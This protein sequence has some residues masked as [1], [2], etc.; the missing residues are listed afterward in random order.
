MTSVQRSN[1]TRITCS[2]LVLLCVNLF[3]LYLTANLALLSVVFF[4]SLFAVV[5]W[6]NAR[7]PDRYFEDLPLLSFLTVVYW[8]FLFVDSHGTFQFFNFNTYEMNNYNT[9]VFLL[10]N[11]KLGIITGGALHDFAYYKGVNFV[12]FGPF[13]AIF[14]LMLKYAFDLT[15]TFSEITLIFVLINLIEFNLLLTDLARFS[16]LDGNTLGTRFLFL[17]LYAIGPLLY[18]TWRY[19]IYET[20]II[21]G[22]TFSL[23]ACILFLRYFNERG[24]SLRVK[25][26][27]LFGSGL[28]LALTFFSRVT[29][30]IIFVPLLIFL[31]WDVFLSHYN[32]ARLHRGWLLLIVFVIP[33]LCAGI[34][35][36]Y[37][38]MIRFGSP[39]EFGHNYVLS[40]VAVEVMRLQAGQV[41]SLGYL[42]RN[43]YQAFFFIPPMSRRYPFIYYNRYPGWLVGYSY[44]KLT[45]IEWGAS[46]FFSSPL[47]SF[48]FLSL[49]TLRRHGSWKYISVLA[50][51]SVCSGLYALSYMSYSRRYLQEFYPYVVALAFLGVIWV[52][53]RLRSFG[54]G[55]RLALTLVLIA[56]FIWTLFVS[57][58]LNLQLWVIPNYTFFGYASDTV[59]EDFTNISWGLTLTILAF[60]ILSVII[61]VSPY[62]RHSNDP[63]STMKRAA[64]NQPLFYDD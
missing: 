35:Y 47:L 9:L 63:H 50:A 18:L 40:G 45:E 49:A 51:L 55:P 64:N 22:S 62:I 52:M 5:I 14:W 38:N 20:A 29:L 56:G 33:V 19:A 2:Y 11:G 44:P 7:Q 58:D 27:L 26:S 57:I 16:G 10:E 32:E 43:I 1:I 21:F 34:L 53:D 4:I 39:F 36:G 17:T 46:I 28:S 30:I 3:A 15:P 61:G 42:V 8:A 13:P 48:A 6:R 24:R 31:V 54:K 60:S 25:Y 12:Y 41:T 37:Y 23:L 59:W